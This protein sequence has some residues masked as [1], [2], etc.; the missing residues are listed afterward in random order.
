MDAD[1]QKIRRELG[2][3]VDRRNKISHGQSESVARRKSLDLADI[4]LTIGD[5]MTGELDPR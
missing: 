5:W 4:A 3:L 1:D 2:F